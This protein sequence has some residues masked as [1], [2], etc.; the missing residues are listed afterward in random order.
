[1]N[2]QRGFIKSIVIILIALFALSYF[3]IFKIEEHVNGTQIRA[4]IQTFIDWVKGLVN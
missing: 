2:T 4:V 3:G 1:M